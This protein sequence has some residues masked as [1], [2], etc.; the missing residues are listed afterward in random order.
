MIQAQDIRLD[1]SW[2]QVRIDADLQRLAVAI[3]QLREC[4]T[5]F[6]E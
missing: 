5:D 6:E 1:V 2:D 4:N 3:A